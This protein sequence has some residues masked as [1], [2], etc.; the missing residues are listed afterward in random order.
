MR[1][2]PLSLRLLAVA[3]LFAAVASVTTA[4]AQKGASVRPAKPVFRAIDR[5]VLNVDARPLLGTNHR[6]AVFP[7]GA[8]DEIADVNHFGK[9]STPIT[10]SLLRMSIANA[11]PGRREVRLLYIPSGQSRF[12]IGARAPVEIQPPRAGALVLNDLT[13]EA[14]A[15]GDAPFNGK[16]EAKEMTIE[17]QFLNFES[18]GDDKKV[19]GFIFMG[20]SELNY[21][22]DVVSTAM[23]IL[24]PEN[25]SVVKRVGAF[26]RGDG[27]L[28]KGYV[29]IKDK[30]I[31]IA[32]CHLLG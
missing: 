4:G 5:I 15:I 22:S 3:G 30:K 23:C 11:P 18:A 6:L 13:R 8:P 27:V 26:K 1:G 7:V 14:R 9:N 12:V 25:V 28:V 2:A 16:Y 31:A 17:G 29:A 24:A 21:P 32:L 10:R 20:E 19:G